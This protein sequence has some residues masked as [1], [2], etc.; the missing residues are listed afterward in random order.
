MTDYTLGADASRYQLDLDFDRLV[1]DGVR[2][3]IIKA[4]QGMGVDPKFE[5]NRS[6]AAKRGMMAFAYP[7]L[8]PS[9][10]DAVIEHFLDVTD[11]MVPA[12][13][14]EQAGTPASD[15]ERWMDLSEARLG[16]DGLAYYGKW[17]PQPVTA[18]ITGWPRW[19]PQYSGN[20]SAPCSLPIW[21]GNA[22][23]PADWSKTA[24]I[25]Q[26]TGTGRLPGVAPQID[27]NR[28]ACPLD[29]LQRWHD[30]GSFGELPEVAPALAK[31]IPAT[32]PTSPALGSR[33]LHLHST[34]PD[35]RELQRRLIALGYPVGASLD[36]GDYGPATVS[37]V[38]A[39]QVAHNLVS[40][41]WVGNAT[42]AA[43]GV[44]I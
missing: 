7:F 12:L 29:V 5:R 42:A 11:G 39:F 18:R 15:V 8:Q 26:Y 27:L 20:D 10:T 30:T 13:D 2:Y 25:W 23:E 38:K 40:D 4:T 28:I 34:G 17:P 36:D 22:P 37:A 32:T 3:I 33:D 14:W 31:P 19:L 44:T 43:L 16:R 1:A 9:D 24:L 35:V 21:A 6:E 41:G